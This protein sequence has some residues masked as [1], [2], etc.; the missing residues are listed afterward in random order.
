MLFERNILQ[1][2]HKKYLHQ[3]PEAQSVSKRDLFG[4]VFKYD[5]NKNKRLPLKTCSI[6]LQKTGHTG[7]NIP[8][9]S[10]PSNILEIMEGLINKYVS[11]WS[12]KSL[13]VMITRDPGTMG[14]TTER[15][16]R[17]PRVIPGY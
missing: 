16:P 6:M 1:L 12:C 11:H 9:P 13:N 5:R 7:N 15:L 8:L 3:Q 14:Q 10:S 17:P 4:D 2:L